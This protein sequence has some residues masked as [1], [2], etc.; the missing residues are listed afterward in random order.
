M[1]DNRENKFETSSMCP[2]PVDK[3]GAMQARLIF[4][5]AICLYVD[6]KDYNAP[7]AM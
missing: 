5:V 4:T 2:N 6:R 3:G 1:F 7:I